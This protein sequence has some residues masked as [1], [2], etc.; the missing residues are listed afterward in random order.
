MA[1]HMKNPPAMQVIQK[2]QVQ[3]LGQE[4]PLQED[5]ATHS[6]ILAGKIPQTEEPGGLQSL[7]SQRMGHAHT[8]IPV[9]DGTIPM[10][11]DA[12]L[13]NT[14]WKREK[15]RGRKEKREKEGG[16]MEERREGKVSKR[17]TTVLL[18]PN[19]RSDIPLVLLHSIH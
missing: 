7:R 4:D 14:W 18:H 3:F 2:T 19:L 15:E 16:R 17:E 1:Q 6:S 10:C 13:L 9:L 12:S 8:K 5:M 11:I